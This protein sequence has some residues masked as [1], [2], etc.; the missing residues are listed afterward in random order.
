MLDYSEMQRM[1]GGEF[2]AVLNEFKVV[3][4]AKTFNEVVAKLKKSGQYR[5]MGTSIRIQYIQPRRG[6]GNTA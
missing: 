3:A 2:I 1:Y 4:H 5:D 6:A